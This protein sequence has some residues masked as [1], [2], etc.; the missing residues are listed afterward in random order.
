[1][2]RQLFRLGQR[3]PVSQKFG[4]VRVAAGGMEIRDAVIGLVG[5]AGTLQIPLDHEPCLPP[6]EFGKQLLVGR[7]SV[8]P[9]TEH[10]YEFRVL[11]KHVFPSMLGKGGFDSNCWRVGIKLKASG[12]EARDFVLAQPS[13]KGKNVNSGPLL[14]SE[15]LNA[16]A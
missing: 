6:G 9:N 15:S 2:S 12:R 4:D 10:L 11:R 14:A 3:S 8:K 5:N 16:N 7:N 1:M 13:H